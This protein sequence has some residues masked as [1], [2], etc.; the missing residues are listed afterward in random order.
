MELLERYEDRWDWHGLSRNHG[1][2]WS[3]ELLDRYE[4]RW[5]WGPSPFSHK[6]KLFPVWLK[7]GRPVVSDVMIEKVFQE[8]ETHEKRQEGIRGL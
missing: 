6:L 1:L 2:P 7:V 4:D 5:V 3:I 8:L